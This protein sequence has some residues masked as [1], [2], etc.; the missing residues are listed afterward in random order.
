MIVT[1]QDVLCDGTLETG[2]PCMAREVH[3]SHRHAK[4][5]GWTVDGNLYYCVPCSERRKEAEEN[6]ES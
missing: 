5:R 2:E 1:R 3:S 4:G 6:D